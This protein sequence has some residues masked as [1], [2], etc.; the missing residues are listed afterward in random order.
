VAHLFSGR[1]FLE[2]EG[3]KWVGKDAI[4][5]EFWDGVRIIGTMKSRKAIM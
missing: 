4:E 2:V 5:R 3:R 1:G